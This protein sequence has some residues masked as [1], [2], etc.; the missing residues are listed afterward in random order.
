VNV[1]LDFAAKGLA[2]TGSRRNLAVPPSVGGLAWAGYGNLLFC[3]DHWYDVYLLGLGERFPLTLGA[4][5]QRLGLRQIQGTNSAR[6]YFAALGA[7]FTA[8]AL[9]WTVSAT[10]LPSLG[11]F[12]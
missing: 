1:A 7:G 3:S 5:R 8:G 9:N 6:S 4:W 11:S 2:F 12:A 10:S